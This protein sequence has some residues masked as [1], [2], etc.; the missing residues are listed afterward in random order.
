MTEETVTPQLIG[1]P[2]EIVS[3]L[4]ADPPPGG[5]GT[6]WHRYVICQ[7]NNTIQGYRQGNLKTVT[8]AVEENV[9]LLNERRLGKRGRVNLVPTPKKKAAQR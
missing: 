7:G 4:R 5:E 3:V 9:A 1:H 2:Y 8:K 6:G